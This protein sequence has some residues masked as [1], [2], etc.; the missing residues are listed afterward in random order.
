MRAI[1]SYVLLRAALFIAPFA[2]LVAAQVEWY[3]ALVISLLFAF[4]AS[5]VF[6][7]RQKA[8]VSAEIARMRGERGHR[9][10][11]DVEDEAV[12]A[13]RATETDDESIDAGADAEDDA[14]DG[15]VATTTTDPDLVTDE[16]A[17]AAERDDRT[18][19]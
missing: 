3:V 14:E 4:A 12:D 8:A 2:I 16:D 17:S 18:D 7:R 19:R 10:D 15:T 6:L 9:D 1:V 5:A 11:E 13:V